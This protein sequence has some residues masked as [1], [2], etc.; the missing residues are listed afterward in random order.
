M[1]GGGAVQVSCTLQF[2]VARDILIFRK[3]RKS[4]N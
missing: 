3:L 2:K 4:R 1:D